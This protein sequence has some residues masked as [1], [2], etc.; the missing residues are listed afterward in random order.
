MEDGDYL[1][2]AAAVTS[3]AVLAMTR[4]RGRQQLCAGVFALVVQ[5]DNTRQSTNRWPSVK[6]GLRGAFSSTYFPV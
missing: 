2:A 3:P 5:R 1:A 6:V 4:R